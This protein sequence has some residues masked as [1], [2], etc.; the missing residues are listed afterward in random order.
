MNSSLLSS[1]SLL[2]CSSVFLCNHLLPSPFSE[3]LHLGDLFVKYGYI[4]PLQEPKNLTLKTDGSLYRFQVNC[5]LSKARELSMR[6]GNR[7][8]GQFPR[9]WSHEALRCSHANRSGYRRKEKEIHRAASGQFP[10]PDVSSV[11]QST[12][13]RQT[14][15]LPLTKLVFLLNLKIAVLSSKCMFPS[16]FN[17]ANGICE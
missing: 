2:N 4:Y 13:Y 17:V 1:S 5:T 7:H 15:I 14:V 9:S 6:F 12:V 3:A 10:Q 16:R 8:L 11:Y